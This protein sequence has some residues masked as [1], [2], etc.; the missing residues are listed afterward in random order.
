[1]IEMAGSAMEMAAAESHE[2][3]AKMKRKCL[4]FIFS[5]VWREI[6][7]WR[8]DALY[9]FLMFGAFFVNARRK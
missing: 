3:V 9:S 4:R 8:F 6:A 2:N 7:I 5:R 1:V